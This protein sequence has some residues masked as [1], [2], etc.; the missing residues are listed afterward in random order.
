M[1]RSAGA[2]VSLWLPSRR[3]YGHVTTAGMEHL[4]SR[5]GATSGKRSQTEHRRE[6]STRDDPQPFAAHGNLPS[7]DGKEGVNGSSPLEGSAKAPHVGAFAFR[8]TCRFSRVRWVWSRLWSFRVDGPLPARPRNCS[9]ERESAAQQ[10]LPTVSWTAAVAPV[11]FRSTSVVCVR[12]HRRA[13][14]S[15]SRPRKTRGPSTGTHWC[16]DSEELVEGDRNRS[17]S[18]AGGVVDAVCD[19][20]R[21]ADKPDLTES[22]GAER[23]Q[24][25]GFPHEDDVDVGHIL[26]G[27]LT[28]FRFGEACGDRRVVRPSP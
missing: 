13:S 23:C 12:H 3:E 14:R 18:P 21:D 9:T 11:V 10:T 1:V 5:A 17:D 20:G 4:W 22:L 16:G 24:R 2:A 8:S 28:R 19:G 6:R 25:V 7:L 26:W 27:A 15:P